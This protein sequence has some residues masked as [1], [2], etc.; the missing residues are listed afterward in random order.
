MKIYRIVH[1]SVMG[2]YTETETDSGK[3]FSDVLPE[4]EKSSPGTD[5]NLQLSYSTA[6]TC[7]ISIVSNTAIVYGSIIKRYFYSTEKN[8]NFK[9]INI[10]K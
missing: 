4:S 1:L 5:S 10:K 9:T 8:A 6:N 2:K 7:N 3:Q